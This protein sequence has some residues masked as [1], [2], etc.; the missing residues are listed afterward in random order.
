MDLFKLFQYKCFD[1]NPNLTDLHRRLYDLDPSIWRG[2]LEDKNAEIDGHPSWNT[3]IQS[4]S[5]LGNL[6]VLRDWPGNYKV[7]EVFCRCPEH[8]S[9]KGIELHAPLRIRREAVDL[10]S[11][12]DKFSL[13]VC[14]FDSINQGQVVAIVRG[15]R[16]RPGGYSF[17]S[18]TGELEA[19]NLANASLVTKDY[20]QTP[21]LGDS[22]QSNQEMHTDSSYKDQ[23]ARYT[24][25]SKLQNVH[26]NRCFEK[27]SSGFRPHAHTFKIRS[28]I[29]R[30][31][32]EDRDREV[33]GHPSW[34]SVVEEHLKGGKL[35]PLVQAGGGE[36]G[37]AYCIGILIPTHSLL[38]QLGL[39]RLTALG[40]T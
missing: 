31:S 34:N 14:R 10:G 27:H 38:S 17:W 35:L 1:R 19:F 3:V 16:F 26:T 7:L 18:P 32:L 12:L 20:D 22:K 25:T 11:P 21:V 28:S 8:Y 30:G 6:P 37:D 15:H 23:P 13:Q 33:N 36:P 29:W 24:V 5:Q 39:C 40:R 4:H 9:G 2:S